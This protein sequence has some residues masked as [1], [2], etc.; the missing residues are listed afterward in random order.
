MAPPLPTRA[1]IH[2]AQAAEV[3]ILGS[4]FFTNSEMDNSNSVIDGIRAIVRPE[5][6]SR[7]HHGQI[8]AVMEELHAR[9]GGKLD[10]TS[11]S[12]EL[13]RLELLN[14]V[15]GPEYIF[16]VASSVL[17]AHNA[18][19]HARLVSDVAKMRRAADGFRALAEKAETGNFES[20]SDMAEAAQELA[21]DV[22]RGTSRSGAYTRALSEVLADS[23]VEIQR[24]EQDKRAVRGIPT[25]FVDMDLATTGFRRGELSI[26]AA[27][28]AMG[29]TALAIQEGT[30]SAKITGEATVIFS[31][32]MPA[33]QLGTRLI[34]SF[35]K[36]NAE[37]LR[38]GYLFDGALDR[39]VQA[40]KTIGKI[41]LYVNDRGGLTVADMRAELSRLKANPRAP[42]L[43]LVIVDYLQIVR[44]GQGYKRS[45]EQEVAQISAD[46][47]QLAKDFDVH[48]LALSQLNRSLES[49]P[50]KRPLMS[51]LRE[52]GSL[53]QDASLIRFIYRDEVYKEDSEFKG[54][55][56]VIFGKNRHGSIRRG[57]DRKTGAVRLAFRKEFVRFENYAWGT[58]G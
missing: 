45:R 52:S 34:S 19:H 15:G 3:S 12:D 17:T 42:R 9:D 28:P 25:G 24:A 23:L 32:E 44:A 26:L 35:G 29:K 4:I 16:H 22:G 7:P 40:V 31:L 13:L 20:T 48:V 18:E 38:T 30:Q 54:S 11:V 47:L 1:K 53:E 43:A 46:L 6:F 39:A 14:H 57:S 33:E 8:F 56:E 5:D 55:A 50:D 41:P 27:R 51:D 37:S 49:R 58:G 36:V 21:L 10:P 2:E